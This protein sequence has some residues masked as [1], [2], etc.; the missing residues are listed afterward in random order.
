[1]C[2]DMKFLHESSLGISLVFI[3][4]RYCLCFKRLRLVHECISSGSLFQRSGAE[5]E[6]ALEP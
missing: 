4:Y 6:N 1:M 3:I 2:E 5:I